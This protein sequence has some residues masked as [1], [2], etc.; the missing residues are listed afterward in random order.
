MIDRREIESLIKSLYAAR[1]AG[2]IETIGA[3]FA[4]DATFQVAGSPEASPM[5]TS[6]KGHAGIMSLT[7]S[8]MD[9]FELSDFSILDLLIDGNKA[10][11]RWKVT[12]HHVGTAQ[13]FTTELANFIEVSNHEIVSFVEFLD[14]AQGAEVFGTR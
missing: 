2:D 1:T 5:P 3:L 10:A 14:T 8:M 7:Q 6:I 4:Q 12:V 11:V 13:S 9:S